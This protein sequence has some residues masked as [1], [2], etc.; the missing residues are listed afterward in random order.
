MSEKDF[1][2]LG[3][4][5]NMDAFNKAIADKTQEFAKKHKPFDEPCARLEFKDKL[6][7]AEKESER[8]NGFVSDNIKIDI[9]DLD[10]FGK[11]DRFELLEDQEDSQD[12]VIEGSRTQ[13]VIGHTLSYKCKERGHGISVF[14]PIGEYNEMKEVKPVEVKGNKGGK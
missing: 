6:D 4:P 1:K 7:S 8:I 9:G 5:T 14:V 10:K 13:V 11:E 2:D 3:T 12:R